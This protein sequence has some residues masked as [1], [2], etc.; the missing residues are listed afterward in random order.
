MGKTKRGIRLSKEKLIIKVFGLNDLW[1]S[2]KNWIYVN[3]GVPNN[4]FI[5]NCKNQKIGNHELSKT[6][7]V[8]KRSD[9]TW[10]RKMKYKKKFI[11]YMDLWKTG[12]MKWSEN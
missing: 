3:D 2:L 9:M 11:E 4:K 8:S 7:F 5:K 10:R 6:N 12:W 1:M